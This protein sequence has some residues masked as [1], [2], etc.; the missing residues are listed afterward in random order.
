MT[1]QPRTPLGRPDP[2]TLPVGA[3]NARFSG[4]G[5]PFLHPAGS[6]GGGWP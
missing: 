1:R 5:L 3:H 2:L 4:R 6:S